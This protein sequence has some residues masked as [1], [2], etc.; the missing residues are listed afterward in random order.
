[1][2]RRPFFSNIFLLLLLGLL[3]LAGCEKPHPNILLINID[4]MGWR[5]VGFMGSEFYETPNIDRLAESGMVFTNGYAT[6]SNCAPS[7]ACLMS[8]QWTPR[9]GIFT[10]GTSERGK[11]RDRKLI[12]TKN[13]TILPDEKMI[14]IGHQAVRNSLNS[15]FKTTSIY[16][17]QTGKIILAGLKNITPVYTAI[18]NVIIVTLHKI[19]IYHFNDRPCEGHSILN[20]YNKMTNFH[21][22]LRN[23]DFYYTKR[24]L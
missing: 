10:V 1:M 18:E 20:I 5:D 6:A 7:R 4:D 24:S 2:T 16:S 9:H 12:P 3:A 21:L 11:S 13:S 14:M 22:Y 15:I 19:S 17:L 8:G 23:N